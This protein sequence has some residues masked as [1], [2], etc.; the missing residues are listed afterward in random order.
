[1]FTALGILLTLFGFGA[2]ILLVTGIV[3]TL[4]V[5]VPLDHNTLMMALVGIGLLGVFFLILGR[6][7]AN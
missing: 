7:P 5:E 3:T 4:P 6:R 2:W 1:M